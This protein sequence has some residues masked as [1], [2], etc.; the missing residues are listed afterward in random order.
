M[1]PENVAIRRPSRVKFDRFLLDREDERVIGPTG[2]IRLGNKAFRVLE[3][4]V[5]SDG[6]LLT[7]DTLFETVWD[8]TH[9]SESALTSVI[10][11][12][13]RALGDDSRNARLIESVY[14]RGYRLLVAT[15]AEG[16]VANGQDSEDYIA[17]MGDRPWDLAGRGQIPMPSPTGL[18]IQAKPSIAVVPFV[19]VGDQSDEWFPDAV[20]EEIIV[21]LARFRQFFV[22]SSIT[23]LN[24]RNKGR[25]AAEISSELNVRYVLSGTIQR[26][27]GRIRFI[28]RLDD[29]IEG[30]T[31]WTEKFDENLDDIFELQ[32]R[33]ALTVAGRIGVSINDAEIYRAKHRPSRNLRDLYWQANLLI[34]RIEPNSIAAALALAE[35]ALEIEPDNA[36]AA[37][38]AAL[39]NGFQFLLGWT[40]DREKSRE[41]TIACCE[42]ALRDPDAD[43][44]VFGLCGPALNCVGHNLEL[45]NQ[46]TDKAI[47]INPCDAT[48]LFWGSWM[49][50]TAGNTERAVERAQTSL[51]VN[52]L[53]GMRHLIAIPL[54]VAMILDG[55]HGEA[56]E[57]LRAVVEISP[58]GDALAALTIALVQM[59][60][61]DEARDVYAR[62]KAIGGAIGGLALMRKPEHVSLVQDSLAR[63][64][65]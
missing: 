8:G 24:G 6:K 2:P 56:A 43:E 55:H 40:Q 26:S 11:E 62:L 58:Q 10:K 23:T 36:W 34:R 35:R 17:D 50:V 18:V 22:L 4:L 13:R 59:G 27:G 57:Q 14:G 32:D 45:A 65:V 60:R 12:L 42:I 51:L 41:R 39:A 20:A 15:Q 53:S 64:A 1:E 3:A 44:R 21:A 37:A 25:T 31:I 19:Q 28:A 54:A 63:A 61:I 5:D 38:M 52:P 48:S 16:P 49:D 33:I 30:R 47:E 46:L 29:G 7:K 9:V